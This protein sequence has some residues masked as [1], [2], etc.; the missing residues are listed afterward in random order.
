[1]NPSPKFPIPPSKE[2]Q[3]ALDDARHYKNQIDA[4]I[5]RALCQ[6]SHK[7]QTALRFIGYGFQVVDLDEV[8]NII[9]PCRQCGPIL[10]CSKHMAMVG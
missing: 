2:L 9:E 7:R 1:M 3:Q 10:L 8:G 4:E 5:M 6:P